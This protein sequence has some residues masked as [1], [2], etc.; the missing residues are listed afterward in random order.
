MLIIGIISNYSHALSP[1]VVDSAP[2]LSMD[3]VGKSAECY[4]AFLYQGNYAVTD[5]CDFNF[6]TKLWPAWPYPT[7]DYFLRSFWVRWANPV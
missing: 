4:I 6:A 1:V 3:L 5:A 2:S 7:Q